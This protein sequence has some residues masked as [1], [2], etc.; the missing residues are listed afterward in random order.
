MVLDI[1]AL[2]A[3]FSLL[4]A[5][6]HCN[7]DGSLSDSEVRVGGHLR[8]EEVQRADGRRKGQRDMARPKVHF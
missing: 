8:E 3:A 7:N 4:R 6:A 1:S 2:A 5:V